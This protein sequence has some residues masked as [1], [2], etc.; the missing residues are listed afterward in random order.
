M[1]ALLLCI[2]A[3][4]SNIKQRLRSTSSLVLINLTSSFKKSIKITE[5]TLLVVLAATALPVDEI[6]II[7]QQEFLKQIFLNYLLS[8]SWNPREVFLR[9]SRE[10]GFIDVN[11][12]F[13]FPE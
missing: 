9:Q 10:G 11:H 7:N 13:E 4:S 3:L 8:S 2:D 12:H 1:T 6:A 5:F